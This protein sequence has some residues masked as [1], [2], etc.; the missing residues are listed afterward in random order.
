MPR[1]IF[2][3]IEMVNTALAG[4]LAGELRKMTG[5]QILGAFENKTADKKHLD[6]NLAAGSQIV[7][8]DDSP[9]KENIFSKINA[10]RQKHPEALIFMISNDQRPEYIIS[11][12]KAGAAE[13]FFNPPDYSKIRA[14]I[15]KVR[16]QV[17]E[18]F[19]SPKGLLYSFVSAKGGIGSTLL[20]VNTA[21]GLMS[22]REKRAAVLDFGLHSGDVSVVLDIVPKTTITDIC[23]NFNRLDFSFLQSAMTRHKSGV[24]FLAA[25]VSP[26]EN[27]EVHAQHV[28]KIIKLA[29]NAFDFT[30][31]DCP[32]MSISDRSFEAFGESEKIIVLTDLSVPSV[33]NATRLTKVIQKRGINPQKIEI[34]VNRFIKGHALG[35]DEIEKTLKKRVFWLFPND[36]K[37]AMTSIN[38]GAPLIIDQPKSPLSKNIF[39]FID[40]LTDSPTDQVYR[41]IKGHFG[42]AI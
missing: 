40:K 36:Y 11:V 15:E 24:S 35:L 19:P 30:V 37:A 14:A 22:R 16:D 10:T 31:V 9:E 18:L 38:N 8:I 17:I 1:E 39:E 26:E 23:H 41:G 28:N 25:P 5:V 42:K 20:A 27:Q 34:A 21:V 33:R 6:E 32:S 12:M 2:V 3:S 13:I 4:E 7:F 29:K